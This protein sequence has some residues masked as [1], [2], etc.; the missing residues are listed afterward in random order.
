MY[1]VYL[2][3]VY[4]QCIYTS[5]CNR[6]VYKIYIYSL[7]SLYI[8]RV[9]KIPIEVWIITTGRYVSGITERYLLGLKY[10]LYEDVLEVVWWHGLVR[11]TTYGNSRYHLLFTHSSILLSTQLSALQLNLTLHSVSSRRSVTQRTFVSPRKIY[12]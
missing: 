3:Y 4:I 1:N 10:V 8:W 6:N 7:Y 2:Y 11:S 12:N 9:S 5:I